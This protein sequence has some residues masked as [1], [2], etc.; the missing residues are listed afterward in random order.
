MVLTVSQAGGHRRE[1]PEGSGLQSP[2][3][4]SLSES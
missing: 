4:L 3:V 2:R 1:K